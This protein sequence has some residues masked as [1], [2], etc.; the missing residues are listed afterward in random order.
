MSNTKKKTIE[1]QDL[2]E[3]N[4]DNNSKET[5]TPLTNINEGGKNIILEFKESLLNNHKQKSTIRS[6]IFDVNSFI[7]FIESKGE[8]FE[9]VFNRNQFIE[10]IKVQQ[11][12]NFKL[13]TINKRINSLQSFNKFLINQELM[14]EMIVNLVDDKIGDAKCEEEN[15]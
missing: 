8:I 3:N 10:Y 9:G 4:Q 6:Y 15:Q 14:K 2:D 5:V 12:A 7:N 13:N 11:E 1:N